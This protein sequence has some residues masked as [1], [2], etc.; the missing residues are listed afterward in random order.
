[1]NHEILETRERT[2][3]PEMAFVSLRMRVVASGPALGELVEARGGFVD[4]AGAVGGGLGPHAGVV[5]HDGGDGAKQ[6]IDG[7]GKFLGVLVDGVGAEF[8]GALGGFPFE[9]HLPHETRDNGLDQFL[10]R[11][12]FVE[13]IIG[14]TGH[15]AA[16]SIT[17]GGAGHE[18]DGHEGKMGELAD[19]G[20]GLVAVHVGHV[21]VAQDEVGPMGDG[22]MKG[23]VGVGGLLGGEAGVRER[24]D[25]DGPDIVFVV[26][27]QDFLH[28]YLL[29]KNHANGKRGGGGAKTTEKWRKVEDLAGLSADRV[30]R[31]RQRLPSGWR[32]GEDKCRLRARTEFDKETRFAMLGP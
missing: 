17:I 5:D 14:A 13:E 7:G 32:T 6:V 10:G 20:K 18:D 3:G 9:F 15:A 27:N 25:D 30:W 31:T 23:L 21:D 8:F 16:E 24:G 2:D 12:G 29:T 28:K 26:D 19:G 11:K 1:M 22:E 4:L